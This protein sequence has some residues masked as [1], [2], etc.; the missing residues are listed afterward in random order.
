M[1]SNA[2]VPLPT[3]HRQ[4][5]QNPAFLVYI[6]HHAPC[7]SFLPWAQKYM[8]VLPTLPRCNSLR[9]RMN[10]MQAGRRD[11]ETMAI[12]YWKGRSRRVRDRSALADEGRLAD[13]AIAVS[14]FM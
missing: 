10:D 3:R 9:Q 12:W 14:A 4:K 1:T 13:I 2:S 11:S 5:L 6:R 8:I 7:L